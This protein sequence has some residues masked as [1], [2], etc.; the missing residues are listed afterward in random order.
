MADYEREKSDTKITEKEIGEVV[1]QIK[2][3]AFNDALVD[4]S[5]EVGIAAESLKEI[6]SK[7]NST[8][9]DGVKVDEAVG[10]T[11]KDVSY[12][13]FSTFAPAMHI[14]SLK[15]I[16][17]AL[18][19]EIISIEVEPYAIARAVKGG[20]AENYSSIIID[21]GGGTTDIAVVDRGAVAATK[22]FAYGGKVF[23]KRIAHDLKLELKEAEDQK[24]NYANNQLKGK[25]ES[26]IKSALNKD[27]PIWAEG[28]EL[29]LA[30][31]EDIEDFPGVIYICGGGSALPDMREALQQHPW[32]QVLPFVKFPKV[33][34][35]FPNN[36]VD[37]IDETKTIIDPA[38][39]APL[40]LAR[41]AL[42]LEKG[43]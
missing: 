17:K 13:I 22:M 10:L 19:L 4:I 7:V 1:H 16:A 29:A 15:E 31:V 28:V 34:F 11:G 43:N 21:I 23:T 42:E 5:E 9:I 2:S 32:L 24:L 6:N 27:L 37:V 30:E 12:R 35:L 25:Q 26:E 14:N 20:R 40:A 36:L 38:D 18:A 8:Y 3:Q 33:E 39:I 41:M